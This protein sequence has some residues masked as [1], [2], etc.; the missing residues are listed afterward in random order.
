[1]IWKLRLPEAEAEGQSSG[2]KVQFLSPFLVNGFYFSNFVRHVNVLYRVM[3]LLDFR[4]MSV[5]SR[6]GNG[7]VGLLFLFPYYVH[8][9]ISSHRLT[10]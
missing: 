1:M 3:V 10:D 7:G 4:L 2:N 8:M 5:L 6:L 9:C